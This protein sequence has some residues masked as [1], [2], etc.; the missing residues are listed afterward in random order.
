[1]GF[2]CSDTSTVTEATAKDSQHDENS[3]LNAT[4]VS[5]ADIQ[6]VAIASVHIMATMVENS[7]DTS[8][9]VPSSEITR[10][11]V[12]AYGYLD[13]LVSSFNMQK[14]QISGG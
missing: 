14:V 8:G 4:V 13:P 11:L 9:T 12:K 6:R 5:L 10:V 7:I 3:S 1:M 2:S